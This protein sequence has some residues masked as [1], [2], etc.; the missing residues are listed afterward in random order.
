MWATSSWGGHDLTWFPYARVAKKCQLIADHSQSH[1]QAANV[2]KAA[3]S[4][5][6]IERQN[7]KIH[8]NRVFH[9]KIQP[10]RFLCESSDSF[11]PFANNKILLRLVWH[12]SYDKT[13]TNQP[14]TESKTHSTLNKRNK[15]HSD[16]YIYI[17]RYI[18]ILY[19]QTFTVKG[20]ERR[21]G[22]MRETCLY[23]ADWE[24]LCVYWFI[25]KISANR[26][27]HCSNRS[28]NL[29][30]SIGPYHY[31]L[32]MQTNKTEYPWSMI[33]LTENAFRLSSLEIYRHEL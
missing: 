3:R 7:S 22:S 9:R 32:K 31:H 19:I 28:I 1:T 13:I 11:A 6:D 17:D 24:P 26:I 5:P 20:G 4:R 23:S 25:F 14:T 27:L 21:A 12:F 15:K 33:H 10:T 29:N 16:I 2:S 18:Q 8:S 30:F